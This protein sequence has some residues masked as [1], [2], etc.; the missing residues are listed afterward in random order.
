MGDAAEP[1]RIAKWTSIIVGGLL[2]LAV[3]TVFALTCV[4][5]PNRYRG[6]VEGI[7]GDL[8]G[9]PFVIEGPL[10][11]TWYPWLGVR[12]GAAHLN[13]LPGVEGPP[14]MEWQ[15]IAV[16]AKVWPLLKG[17]VVADRIRLQGPRIHLRR[18]PQGHG[19]WEKL[20]PGSVALATAAA[21]GGSATAATT[22]ASATAATTG[23]SATVA[24]T[25]ASATA[26]R[27]AS[28]NPAATATP[29]TA[30]PNVPAAATSS[31]AARNRPLQI[32]G[33]EVRDGT[34]DYVDEVSGLQADLSSWELN[35]GEWLTGQPLPVHT[36][37]LVRTKS[38][39]ADGVWVQV[40]TPGL[41]IRP[42]P[43]TVV[44]PKLSVRVA[45]AQIDG[46][47]TY[48]QTADTHVRAHGSVA[49]RAPSLRKLA[50]DLGLNQTMPHD[51]TTLGPV[52][53]TTGWSYDDGSIAAKPLALKLDGVNFNGWVER[54]AAP[55]AMWAFELHGDHIDLGR[56]VNVD[57]TNKKP[58]ELPVAALHAINANGSVL[59]DQVVL[60]NTHLANVRL[61]LQT[62]EAKP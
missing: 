33:I 44:A 38:L 57:S 3:A 61:N 30:A 45:D 20:G 48:E 5:D 27:G 25:E 24:A 34:V 14:L 29:A 28:A 19:N 37:F 35:V 59:F 7:V 8:V 1:V 13:N 49:L 36:R 15:S 9:R 4:V 47:L 10:Q 12:T 62:P 31:A 52:E 46:D 17:E 11:I 43:L 23:A 60:A 53:L 55:Q 26:A 50:N 2:V 56:Y 54:T 16:A 51:P 21:T 18:D 40:D 22:E 41:A 6:K 42:E 32:A 58:F 39:P